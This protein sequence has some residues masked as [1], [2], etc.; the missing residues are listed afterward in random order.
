[1]EKSEY[2]KSVSNSSERNYRISE[3]PDKTKNVFKNADKLL[4]F[5]KEELSIEIFRKTF[6]IQSAG[7][8]SHFRQYCRL[9]CY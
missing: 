9:F 3:A 2:L 5:F 1:M 7:E 4:V 6:I 8:S